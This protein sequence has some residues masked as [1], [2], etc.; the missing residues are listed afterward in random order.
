MPSIGTLAILSI[1]IPWTGALAVWLARDRRPA[2]QHVLAV[3]FALA[4][5]VAAVAMIPQRTEANVF[6]A[7]LGSAFGELTFLPDGLA[8]FLAV[9]ATVIGSLAVIFSLDYMRGERQQARYYALVLFFIGAMV[10]LVLS[11]NL[12][13]VFV[14]WEITAFCSY[15]LI[16]FYND[17]PKAVAA[18]IKALIMTQVGGVGLLAGALL[19]YAYQG[20]YDVPTFLAAAT[21]LP[22]EVLAVMA[23]GFLVAAAAKSA[24]FP[25][26]TWLP[27]AMEA[28]TP[29]SALIHAATMVNAGVYLLARFYPAFEAVPHWRLAV[30]T[31]G[32]VTALMAAVMA[33]VSN[34][35]KRV[36]AHSTVSQL[37]Y[38]VYAI[39][40][41]G[42]FASQFH[43][44]SHSV[45]KALLFLSAG[46][47]I[48]AVHTRD[49][50]EMGGLGRRMPL[51]RVVMLI[52]ALALAGIPIV[53]G[54]WS[55]ELILEVG[56]EGGPA[57]AWY[58]MLAGAGLTAL[59]TL[60]FITMVFYGE[61]HAKGHVHDAGPAMKVALVPL[62]LGTL[63]TWLIAGDFARFLGRAAAG[64]HGEAAA[65]STGALLAQVATAPATL[66]ALLVIA[67]GLCG[68]WQ[69]ARLSGLARALE[70]VAVMARH[71]FG[72]EAINRGIVGATAGAAESLRATQPGI[73]NWNVMAILVGLV[74]V[75]AILA[76]GGA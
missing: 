55:K 65:E 2:L 10:G 50:R 20:S 56:H 23:F 22:P 40:A 31:V 36:L 13:L 37:G 52:G 19:L 61:P 26:Q 21:Q 49:M 30:I 58:V 18:G 54:F 68:Y 33:I 76:L 1:A 27:D 9:V 72:F 44:L 64:G 67:A 43:L 41:G 48:H 15:A 34:D 73:L 35:L 57:W 70:G 14:F 29:I 75:L 62:A 46:A 69:R 8:V 71:N 32:A 38:M 42:V 16:S 12:L 63:T 51:T 60:R 59:Y 28:P 45:F 25:F 7:A 3:G 5:G 4:G 11:S 39:G 74:V 47:V 6:G 24:Q 17:D 53:N 66:V